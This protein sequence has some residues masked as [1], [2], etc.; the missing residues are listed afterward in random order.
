MHIPKMKSDVARGNSTADAFEATSEDNSSA[1]EEVSRRLERY[2]RTKDPAALWPGLREA[3]RVAG[4]REI[5]RVTRAVLGGRVGESID[6][7]GG[8]EPYALCIAGHTTDGGCSATGSKT[9]P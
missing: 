5:E 1:A 2:A 4:A 7:A 9:E 3:A 8:Y 6:H